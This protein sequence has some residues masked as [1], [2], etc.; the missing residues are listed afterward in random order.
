MKVC[1]N[2][3]L[4]SLAPQQTAIEHEKE[5]KS[6]SPCWFKAIN[7]KD[8]NKSFLFDVELALALCFS[9]GNLD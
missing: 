2:D 8:A 9:F 4:P 3:S 5:P 6:V 7:L 1:L